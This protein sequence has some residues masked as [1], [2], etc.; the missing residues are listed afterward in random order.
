MGGI[1]TLAKQA[2]R[3]TMHRELVR[4]RIADNLPCVNKGKLLAEANHLHRYQ[5]WLV[6]RY[7]HG[8]LPEDVI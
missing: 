5:V 6:R 4:R 1:L 3:R 8:T 7:F 2:L